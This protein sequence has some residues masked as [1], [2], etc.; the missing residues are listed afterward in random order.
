MKAID[1]SKHL[2]KKSESKA[3]KETKISGTSAY[4]NT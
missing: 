4:G 3:E 1:E 2:A